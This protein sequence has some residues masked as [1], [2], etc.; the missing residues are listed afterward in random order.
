MYISPIVSPSIDSSSHPTV[1]HRG[2]RFASGVPRLAAPVAPFARH[3][4]VASA[5]VAR[6]LTYGD[7]L[8]SAQ[9][10]EG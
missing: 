4:S 2:H 3:S 7:A 1:R 5:S 6:R 10:A 9:R 8:S